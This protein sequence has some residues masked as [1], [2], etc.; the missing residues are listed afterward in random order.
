[1]KIQVISDSQSLLLV[2]EAAD[3]HD[4]RARY[5]VEVPDELGEKA[6]RVQRE[7]VEIQSLLKSHGIDG[8][9]S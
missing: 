3:D 4:Y 5:N 2:Y 9:G 6:L 1:M 7:Y 8:K